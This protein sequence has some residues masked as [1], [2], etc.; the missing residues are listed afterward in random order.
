MYRSNQFTEKLELE[1]R[2]T[3]FRA[4]FKYRLEKFRRRLGDYEQLLM[5]LGFLC[6]FSMVGAFLGLFLLGLSSW[7]RWNDKETFKYGCIV[8]II[9]FPICMAL[10]II[11]MQ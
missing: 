6:I 10:L 9:Y 8:S 3:R 2:A 4:T 1:S 5:A 7:A 11:M